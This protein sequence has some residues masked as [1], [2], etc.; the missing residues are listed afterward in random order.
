MAAE[1]GEQMDVADPETREGAGPGAAEAGR[2]QKRSLITGKGTSNS[3]IKN[4]R[5]VINILNGSKVL[6]KTIPIPPSTAQRCA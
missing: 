5:N 3:S 2:G 1:E 4:R 6:S